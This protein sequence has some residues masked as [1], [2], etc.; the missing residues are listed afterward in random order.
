[1]SL[2][3]WLDDLPREPEPDS[4]SR[5][6]PGDKTACSLLRFAAEMGWDAEQI[7]QVR[8]K[9]LN[10]RTRRTFQAVG[11]HEKSVPVFLI[12]DDSLVEKS[13][14]HIEAVDYQYSHSTGP[15]LLGQVWMTSHLVDL[16]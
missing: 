3:I 4:L 13:S 11:R 8:G 2:C 16:R 10:R 6:I 7:E 1:M 9:M 15:T 12:V 14:Q 5:V